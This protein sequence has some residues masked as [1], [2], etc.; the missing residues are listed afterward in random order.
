MKRMMSA[1]ALSMA[2]VSTATGAATAIASVQNVAAVV[3]LTKV[4]SRVTHAKVGA[5]DVYVNK[6]ST[7]GAVVLHGAFPAG[8]VFNP[9]GNPAVAMLVAGMLDKG[10]LQEDKLTIA[11]RLEGVGATMTFRVDEQ[12]LTFEVKCLKEDLPLVMSLL[13]E[14]LRTPA[15]SPEELARLKQQTT[16]E[17]KRRT[18]STDARAEEAFLRALY[19]QTHPNWQPSVDETLAG[20]AATTVTDLKQFHAAHYGPAHMTLVAVGDV[21]ASRLQAQLRKGFAGWRGGTAVPARSTAQIAPSR[22]ATHEQPTQA[23]ET[24][25]PIRAVPMAGK[26]SVSIRWGESTGLQYRDPDALALHVGTA[27]LGSGFT[28][29]LMD[30]VRDREGLTYGIRARIDHDTF[31]DGDFSVAATFAPSLLET[32]IASTRRELLNWWQAGV[33]ADELSARKT[34]LIGQYQVGLASPDD[35]ADT[36]LIALQRGYDLTWLDQY[37][38]AINALTLEQVNV[39]IKRHI[40]PAKLVLVEAGTLE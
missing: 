5:M 31:V 26:T 40:D 36:L 12:M 37:P 10:T 16:G 6:T 11:Q 9:Q 35:L 25:D 19:T 21:D 4:A 39:A 30:S 34:N 8:R 7:Q 38:Q 23:A 24:R 20:V 3:T 15:F 1:V 27:I 2:A 17:L 32:G 28:G 29:R 14:Q 33:T 22:S 13:A 18:E